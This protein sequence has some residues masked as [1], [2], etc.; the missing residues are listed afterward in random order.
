[1]TFKHRG[2]CISHSG[3]KQADWCLRHNISIYKHHLWILFMPDIV[4]IFARVCI[5]NR[6]RAAWSITGGRRRNNNH[7][8]S[9]FICRGLG[10]IQ[11]FSASYSYQHIRPICLEFFNH[12][13]HFI[14]R[15]FAAKFYR[16]IF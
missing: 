15:T 3:N 13:I 14:I 1:M 11:C 2:Q 8:Y 6:H 4:D 9:A 12:S 7:R 5:H 10:S 16:F